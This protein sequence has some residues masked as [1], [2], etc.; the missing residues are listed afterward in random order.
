M[1][2]SARKIDTQMGGAATG[3]E[4]NPT[5]WMVGW[6]SLFWGSALVMGANLFLW[7]WDI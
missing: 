6:Q 4:R 2:G 7:Y 1:A 5:D 3:S